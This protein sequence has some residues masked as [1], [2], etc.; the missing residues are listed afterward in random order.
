MHEERIQKQTIGRI[1]YTVTNG[2]GKMA[3]YASSLTPRE[4]WAVVLYVRALQRSQNAA[5]EDVPESKRTE[6]SSK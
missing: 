5:I 4:R 2:K 6:L 3:G 1:F